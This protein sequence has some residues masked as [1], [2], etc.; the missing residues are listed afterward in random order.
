[1]D[2]LHHFTMLLAELFAFCIVPFPDISFIA[3][4]GVFTIS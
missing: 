4:T 1:M 3:E 2:Y